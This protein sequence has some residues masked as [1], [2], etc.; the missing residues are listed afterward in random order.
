MTPSVNEIGLF[1]VER[2]GPVGE[3]ALLQGGAW[4]SAY[5][6]W[7]DGRELVLRVGRA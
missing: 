2:F 7:A 3:V 6:F 1:L 5:S 4:S